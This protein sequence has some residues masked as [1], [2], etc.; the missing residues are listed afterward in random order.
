[1]N[2]AERIA[3]Y[4]RRHADWLV[5][6]QAVYDEVKDRANARELEAGG[7][8]TLIHPRVNRKILDEADRA[9]RAWTERNPEPASPD[10]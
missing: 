5:A 3:H 4:Q 9:R 2:R 8:S 7:R 6:R 1:V 10:L